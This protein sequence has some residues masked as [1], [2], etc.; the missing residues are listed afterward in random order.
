MAGYVSSL[1]GPVPLWEL[2][3][4]GLAGRLCHLELPRERF[5]G[6]NKNPGRCRRCRDHG[7]EL[8]IFGRWK[9]KK[10]TTYFWVRIL[11]FAS[12]PDHP[13]SISTSHHFP[14]L[15]H[16]FN[17]DITQ[18]RIKGP[19]HVCPNHHFCEA[20]DWRHQGGYPGAGS[21]RII[22]WCVW[23]IRL[24]VIFSY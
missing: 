17:E 8:H 4:N 7:N 5:L 6:K 10:C 23:L 15:N 13:I 24:L 2:E 19:L 14:L 21:K 22:I 9:S 3:V 16:L 18:P 11:H 1:P 20:S 12:L